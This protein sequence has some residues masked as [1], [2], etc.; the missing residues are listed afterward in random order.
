MTEAELM[1]N[2]NSA[3]LAKDRTSIFIAHR[4]RT[5]V[6]ADLIIVLREGRVEEQGT[7]DELLRAG[8]LYHDMWLEQ[9]SDAW[10]EATLV[11]SKEKA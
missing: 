1:R 9:A 8:G 2:I 10:H 6:E 11:N 7:H 3:L 5:I 4:L